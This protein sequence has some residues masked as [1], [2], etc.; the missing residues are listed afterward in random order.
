MIKR[1]K[2]PGGGILWR[3]GE[4]NKKFLQCY[5]CLRYWKCSTI[6]RRNVLRKWANI[7]FSKMIQTSE[8][9]RLTLFSSFFVVVNL[10][11]FMLHAFRPKVR[12][13]ILLKHNL[14]HLTLFQ[15][16]IILGDKYVIYILFFWYIQW[17]LLLI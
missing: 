7:F 10:E 14:S 11:L 12:R 9:S 17:M 5:I 3:G 16:Q 6:F 4:V 15:I 13:F 1:V 8:K 2:C